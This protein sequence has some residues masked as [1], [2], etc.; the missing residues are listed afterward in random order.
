MA[1]LEKT[2][3]I[4]LNSKNIK[5]YEDRGYKITRKENSYGKMTFLKGSRIEVLIS[6]LSCGSKALLTKIC[7]YCKLPS[8]KKCFY[9]D[10]L[11]QRNSGDGKD[12]C[13]NCLSLKRADT[14]EL[15]GA[16]EGNSLLEKFP[17]IALEWHPTLNHKKS[18]EVNY[19]STK[20][21]WWKCN[22]GHEWQA[23]INNRTNRN[24][25]CPYCCNKLVCIDNCLD[26]LMPNVSKEWNYS[27][28][29]GLTPYDVLCGSHQ[30]AWWICEDGHEWNCQINNRTSINN[31]GC[32]VCKE[33]KGEKSISLFLQNKCIDFIQEHT[34]DNCRNKKVLP[35]DFYIPQLKLCIE[36]DGAHHFEPRTFG[37]ISDKQA[38]ENFKITQLH[39]KIKNEFCQKNKIPLIRIPYWEFD[40]IE[41]ILNR[42]LNLIFNKEAS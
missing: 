31:T 38:I 21:A 33:S 37:G 14:C 39:D 16:F 7:D 10:I 15:R 25:S 22:K 1:I 36:Y 42:E 12:S 32:P 11:I 34:F 6:D 35:F 41:T 24:A 27:K 30:F 18:S 29:N 2:V 23:V 5:Y 8:T 17:L 28:N 3:W 40:N 13:I 9:K 19:G 26:T 4:T 20:Y